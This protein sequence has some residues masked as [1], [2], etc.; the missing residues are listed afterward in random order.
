MSDESDILEHMFDLGEPGVTLTTALAAAEV[1]AWTR[2]LAAAGAPGD[3]RSRLDLISALEELKCAAEGLQADLAVDVDAS[4]RRRAAERGE[5]A[6][7]QG[8]GVAA[9]IALARRESHHKGRQRLG[10][11]RALRGE[12]P[13][14]REALRAGRISEWRATIVA[15]ETACL[16]RADRV[17]VDRRIA[18]DPEALERMGDRELGDAVRRLAY[19]LDAEAW[20]MRRRIAESER[21]VTLRPAPDV[22]SRL[23]AELPVAQGVAVYRSLGEHA[24]SLRATGD[25]RSRG[26]LMADTLVSRLLGT[27][28]PTALPVLAH[29]VVADDVLFGTRE[30]AAHLDGHGPIPAE[31]AREL[32]A[33]GNEAGLARLRRLYAKPETGEL[34][35]TDS[36][37]RCFPDGLARL[38]RLRDQICRTPWCDAPIRHRDHSMPVSDKG[39]TSERNGQGLCEACNY[40]KEAFGWRAR[41]SPGERHTV[42]ITTPSRRTY[43]STAPPAPR[44]RVDFSYP[45]TFV[46]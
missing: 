26:Q 44:Y 24:D 32:V 2:R 45:V 40:A 28:Q 22:M 41:P 13:F 16:S 18:G 37:S 3:D 21:R 10:L 11:A 5:P 14:T 8:Q 17:E 29:V 25:P 33:A 6:V 23:S 43:R 31:L 30:D 36:R 7:R 39:T 35:A 34:L 46:A 38:I 19:Q 1:R 12:M 20:V 15:R 42:R 9:E 4:M 27:E